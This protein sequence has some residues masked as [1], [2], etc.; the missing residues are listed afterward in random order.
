MKRILVVDDN[1]AFRGMLERTLKNNGL[2]ALG[3]SD[4]R[5]ALAAASAAD[6]VLL[7][8]VLGLENGWETLRRLR[9][10]TQAPIVLMSGVGVDEDMRL[11]AKKLGA[12][13]VL[14]KPFD[15]DRLLDCLSRL[16]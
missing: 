12:Q 10:V 7:D 11:D 3:A 9:E 4:T 1:E 15:L 8:I 5:Q 13:D 6:A 14:Q 2:E 16:T